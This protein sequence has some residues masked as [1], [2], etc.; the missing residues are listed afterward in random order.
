MSQDLHWQLVY[1]F[2]VLSLN[3]GPYAF[4]SSKTQMGATLH[5]LF[6]VLVLKELLQLSQSANLCPSVT[7]QIPCAFKRFFPS[8]GYSEMGR[9]LS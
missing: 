6:L 5:R 3:S 9:L 2:Q 7:P 8:R 4:K 1:L